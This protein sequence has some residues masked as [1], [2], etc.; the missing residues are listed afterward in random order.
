ML[1]VGVTLATLG[2][3]PFVSAQ[4]RMASVAA[5][6][7]W[8]RFPLT[9]ITTEKLD[10]LRDQALITALQEGNH[11][12][13]VKHAGSALPLVSDQV[14]S[15]VEPVVEG[16]TFEVLTEK[17]LQARADNA[18]VYWSYHVSAPEF[19]WEAAIV[20]V[21]YRQHFARGSDLID[22]GSQSVKLECSPA[23]SRWQCS[24]PSALIA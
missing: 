8:S 4:H 18:G 13:N 21:S 20:W 6:L 23:W 17:Q 11:G 7:R 9:R 22:T 19:T 2:F 12:L 14:Y 24:I 10:R 5:D 1:A 16:F 3:A 15:P